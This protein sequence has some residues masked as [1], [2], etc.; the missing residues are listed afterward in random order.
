[1]SFFPGWAW[2]NPEWRFDL[3]GRGQGAQVFRL[4]LWRSLVL[5]GVPSEGCPIIFPNGS[6]WMLIG[7]FT[8]DSNFL[9]TCYLSCN[10]SSRRVWHAWPSLLCSW[11]TK[12]QPRLKILEGR[13]H[14]SPKELQNPMDLGDLSQPLAIFT[15]LRPIGWR[16]LK[17][18]RT[19]APKQ[20]SVGTGV[21]ERVVLTCGVSRSIIWWSST[22]QLI[23]VLV[24]FSG[25]HASPWTASPRRHN[26]HFECSHSE[27][28]LVILAFS[29]ETKGS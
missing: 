25:L 16:L 2:C 21:V 20:N 12:G 15:S 5:V 7:W 22:R 8:T 28:G 18:T 26:M 24:C 11:N 6:K 23:G 4:W 13:K 1:M 17:L 19:R 29:Y 10:R 3:G 9:P 27:G 14:F